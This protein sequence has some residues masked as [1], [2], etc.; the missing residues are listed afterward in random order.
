MLLAP[1]LLNDM[2]N[3]HFHT[4]LA[5][6]QKINYNIFAAFFP[7]NEPKFAEQTL[8]SCGCELH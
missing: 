2:S 5:L 1:G 7:R 4:F 6:S 8:V 3:L